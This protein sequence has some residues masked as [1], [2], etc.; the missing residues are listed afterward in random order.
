MRKI[1]SFISIL[2]AFVLAAGA[3]S[4]CSGEDLQTLNSTL[5]TLIEL[6]D[7]LGEDTE[8]PDAE[9]LGEYT[10][11]ITTTSGLTA[12]DIPEYQGFGYLIVNDNEPFFDESDYTMEAFETYSELDDLGR[13]GVAYANI[14]EEIMPTEARGDI[15]SVHPSGWHP[16]TDPASWNRCHLIGFQLA[17]ENDNELNLVTGTRYMNVD[18]G[19][20]PFENAVDDYV[21]ET[22][23]H[24]LYRVT[25]VFVGD[26]LVCRGVFME[27]YS[28]E[29]NGAGVEFCVFC[30]N[31]QPG[32]IID[33]ATGE[34]WYEN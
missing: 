3:F 21:D 20:L 28:V 18:G 5:D 22:G 10:W 25:P 24:V 23:H 1:K 14:C 7:L 11:S 8:Y 32:V 17:G 9:A 26:E 13:C 34:S 16:G 30:Y 4:G 33:Y 15:S 6:A 19:M 12:E 29:D 27:A 31:V 2:L